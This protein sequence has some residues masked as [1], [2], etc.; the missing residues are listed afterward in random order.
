MG[1][2]KKKLTTEEARKVLEEIIMTIIDTSGKSLKD[3]IKALTDKIQLPPLP[4][5]IP[6]PP[7]FSS[8][9]AGAIVKGISNE[10]AMEAIRKLKKIL[11]AYKV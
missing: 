5:E 7:N 9:I 8:L 3:F 6:D 11:D 1:L 10:N 4:I 2:F